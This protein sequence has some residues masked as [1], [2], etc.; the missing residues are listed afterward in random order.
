MSTE[1]STH[2]VIVDYS[3][4][5]EEMISAGRYDVHS[6][7]VAERFSVSGQGKKELVIVLFHFDFDIYSTS[8]EGNLVFAEMDK[9]GFSP[10]KVEGLLALGESEPELQLQFSI[11]AWGSLWQSPWDGCHYCPI[12]TR[13]GKHRSI[14]TRCIEGGWLEDT[15]FA[16]VHKE[17][18][19]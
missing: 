4:S 16:A 15:R 6:P 7:F 12:L 5:L 13:C 14:D 10:A 8:I 11:A 9:A 17:E 3:R 19:K 18:Q 1:R 2:R